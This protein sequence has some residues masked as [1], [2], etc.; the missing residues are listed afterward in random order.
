MKPSENDLHA[1]VDDLIAPERRAEVETYLAGARDAAERV[2]V[3]R[4][5]NLQLRAHFNPVL[6]EPV[7]Q[8][9]TTLAPRPGLARYAIAAGWLALGV[10]VGWLANASMTRDPVRLAGFAHR[11]AIAHAVYSPEVRHPVEVGAD[12][13]E[14]LVRWLSKRLGADLKPPTLSAN[15]YE[16]VGGRLLPGD[17]GAVAQFMYQD[18]KGRRLTLYV[19]RMNVS[20]GDTAFRYSR[21][22][23]VSVFYWVDGSLGYALSG[24]LPKSDLLGV[25]TAV[26]K[27]LNP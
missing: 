22:N 14:H 12:Q 10:A 20:Q 25:A 27:Q 9:L 11:A 3:Y 21:D 15:G 13:Q 16:L 23:G 6:D 18:A 26:Y 24:E 1:Y 17:R 19:S 8:R 4:E 7:P 5:Q 2:A